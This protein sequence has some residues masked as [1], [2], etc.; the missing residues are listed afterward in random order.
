MKAFCCGLPGWMYC[1]PTQR[2]SA[3]LRIAFEVNSV[4]LSEVTAS[5]WPRQAMMRS[6]SRATRTP[7]IFVLDPAGKVLYHGRIDETYDSPEKVKSPDL[8]NALEAILAG[9]PV[10]AAR[11][12]AFGCTI[13]RV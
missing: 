9:K 7:E 10:P 6:S 4:P 2:S 5:G 12:K 8:R 3:H 13:K 1:Q 11:T